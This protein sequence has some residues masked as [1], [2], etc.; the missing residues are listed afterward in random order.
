MP[1]VAKEETLSSPMVR[2]GEKIFF[3]AAGVAAALETHQGANAVRGKGGN[4]GN[5]GTDGTFTGFCELELGV[6]PVCPR[7]SNVRYFVAH[8]ESDLS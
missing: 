5:L 4:L 3:L 6:R 8:V 2:N 7:I 1:A